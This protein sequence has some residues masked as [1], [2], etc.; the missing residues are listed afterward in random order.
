MDGTER[1]RTD[2]RSKSPTAQWDKLLNI[3]A[4]SIRDWTIRILLPTLVIIKEEENNF[5]C[6]AI[7]VEMIPVVIKV[8]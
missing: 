1:L 5:L 3:A 2:F 4:I 8:I 7:I 6:H